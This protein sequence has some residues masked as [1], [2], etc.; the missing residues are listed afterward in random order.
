[1]DEFVIVEKLKEVANEIHK[2]LYKNKDTG[3]STLTD[4]ETRLFAAD[5]SKKRE[6]GGQ[7]TPEG[8]Q[9]IHLQRGSKARISRV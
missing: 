1:M 3:S 8:T 9:G 7:R 2:A 6:T 4:R 5:D